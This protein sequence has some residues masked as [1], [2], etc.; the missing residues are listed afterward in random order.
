LRANN[1][2]RESGTLAN[3]R[4]AHEYRKNAVNGASPLQLI[5][6]LYDAALR[7]MEAGKQ[8]T[9]KRDLEAQ[10]IQLQKAQKVVLELMACLDMDQGG[11]IAKNLL[12]LYTYVVNEL[13]RANMEDDYDAVDRC[14]K[15]M[16][17][18]RDSWNQLEQTTAQPAYAA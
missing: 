11:D 7:F 8:A 9:K 2:G 3:G 14:I 18:L 17:D 15:V 1:P 5:I 16:S 4:F 6:M 10:N 13:V 12:A